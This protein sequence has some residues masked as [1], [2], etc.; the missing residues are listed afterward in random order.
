MGGEV[1]VCAGEVTFAPDLFDGYHYTTSA[2]D[3]DL[4][5]PSNGK[6]KCG[7]GE[8][9]FG[10]ERPLRDPRRGTPNHC[11]CT[12]TRVLDFL[13]DEKFAD[14]EECSREATDE[15]EDYKGRSGGFRGRRLT[16]SKILSYTPW[17]LVKVTP[18][19]EYDQ[20]AP[21]SPAPLPQ[22][23]C[24]YEYGV[25]E[26]SF[27]DYTDYGFDKAE[28]IVKEWGA[29]STKPCWVRGLKAVID[30]RACAVAMQPPGALSE[31]RGADEAGL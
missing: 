5:V 21:P 30:G 12:P 14:R 24:A 23:A 18:P 17:A 25:P 15:F 1:C 29:G 10:R 3:R 6:I 9:G 2:R 13:K 7:F 28:N 27:Q 19:S 22:L 8:D 16:K 31:L 11:W 4:T 26:A 20:F